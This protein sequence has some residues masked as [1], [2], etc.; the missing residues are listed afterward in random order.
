M[1]WIG[2]IR[3]ETLKKDAIAGV[4]VA[5]VLIPQSMAYAQL[6]GLPAYYGLYAAFLPPMVAALFGSSRQ[7]ATGPVAVV[8]LLSAVALEPLASSGS[9]G[10]IGYAVL[11]AL[12]VGVFQFLL[13]A[14]RLGVL[15]NF[16]S[17]P[18]INGF[19][20]A[21]A[22]IIASSQLDKL[23]G[24]HVDSAAYHFETVVKVL[25]TAA[26]HLHWP[27][28]LMG[29]AAFVIMYVM[30]V[31][32]PHSPGLLVAVVA[33][34]LISWLTEYE[35]TI[36]VPA[37]AL[38][39]PSAR[40]LIDQYNDTVGHLSGL[41]RSRSELMVRHTQLKTQNQ[42]I[43]AL[44]ARH[45]A[46]VLNLKIKA[47]ESRVRTLRKDLRRLQ[48]EGL[49]YAVDQSSGFYLYGDLPEGTKGD[50]R[51]W[52]MVVRR[53]ELDPKALILTTGG[54]V[55]GQIPGG[56]PA[57]SMPMVDL[58]AIRHLIFYAVVIG[59]LGFMEAI[60]VARAVAAKT[61]QRIDPNQELIGQGLANM[62]GAF[63]RA[64]PVSGSFSRTAVNMKA[65]AT[66]GMS[67]TITSLV[68]LAVLLY[69]T[70]LLYHLPQSVLAAIIM[71]AVVGLI[72]V[73]GFVHAWRA[74]WFDGAISI[75]TFLATLVFA[76]YLDRGILIGVGL[77]LAVFLYKS[78][79]P[80]VVD[81]SL[82]VDR[83]LHD[84]VSYGLEECHFIDVV[85]FDGP[86]FFANASYLEDQIRERRKQKAQLKHIIIVANG[87]NDI[88]ASGQEAL[89]FVVDR[90]R[91]AGLDISISGANESVMAALERTHLTTKIGEDHFYAT[92]GEAINRIHPL[93][94][95]GE[96]ERTCPLK[97]V[98]MAHEKIHA[99]VHKKSQPPVPEKA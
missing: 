58:K 22:L 3:S 75:I 10:Y 12:M 18:V 83:A 82:G 53:N 30:R 88:D 32:A 84:T 92:I 1:E 14:L 69:F 56:V 41:A 48:F 60:S 7:L 54:E 71:M 31:I 17:H 50:G 51:K 80:T 21:A 67:G 11:L 43:E 47:Q 70:P 49:A 74:Q 16:L 90:V 86:L 20:N 33:T 72:N 91:S 29:A 97:T 76:P 26:G 62:A 81:L 73:R 94:H 87:I 6:A 35:R 79:R 57:V 39:A 38:K 19:T 65:G 9:Q 85:R 89:S 37:D 4:T 36:E 34:T 42:A 64:Y 78:M 95:Q 28:L 15:V 24:V 66:T 45:Q 99:D 5:L 2:S 68:V 98:V 52:R 59:L 23:F 8:S 27:T 46:D 55:V 96:N 44:E 77:S 93:T 25:A 61:G 40:Q 13:G 63:T